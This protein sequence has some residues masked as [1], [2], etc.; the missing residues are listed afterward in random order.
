MAFDTDDRGNRTELP[1][2][3]PVLPGRSYWEIFRDSV[4]PVVRFVLV[5]AVLLGAF[6]RPGTSPEVNYVTHVDNAWP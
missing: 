3:T 5:A 6:W 4:W 1:W 2:R